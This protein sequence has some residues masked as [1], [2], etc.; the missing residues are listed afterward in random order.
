MCDWGSPPARVLGAHPFC[1]FWH[2]HAI[3]VHP[4]V[5]KTS[6][7]IVFC[8]SVSE[9]SCVEKGDKVLRISGDCMQRA[10]LHDNSVCVMKHVGLGDNQLQMLLHRY[11][12]KIKT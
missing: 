1:L 3:D 11:V 12:Y 5:V 8:V 7:S 10:I 6:P 4:R 2:V 9:I